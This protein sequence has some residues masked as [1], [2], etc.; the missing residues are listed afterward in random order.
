MCDAYIHKDHLVHMAPPANL[1]P[2]QIKMLLEW[3][4]KTDV[5]PLIKSG[6]FHYEFEF[7]HPFSDGN[8]RMGRMWQTLILYNWKPILGWLPVE[9]L[10]KERQERYYSVLG[11]CDK[12]ADSATFIEFILEA[13]F[14]SLS[15]IIGDETLT[16]KEMMD[17]VGIK[18]R[19]T[20]RQNYLLPAINNN[21]VEMTI[22]EK[23]NNT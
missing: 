10:I 12:A 22:P 16:G 6:V 11:V 8:G 3:A 18:H 9:T 4:E 15:E 23:P 7:I 1:V 2:E 21:Y 19:P 20:F 14:D 5:H 17:R 13:I